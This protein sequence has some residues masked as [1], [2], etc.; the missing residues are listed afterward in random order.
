VNVRIGFGYDIH[1]LT[2]GRKLYIGG[3]EIPAEK[4][5]EGFSDGDALLHAVIDSILGALSLGDIGKHFPPGDERYRNMRSTEMLSKTIK[6]MNDRGA[7]V[8][9]MDCTI[10]LESPKLSP[11]TGSIGESIARITGTDRENISIKAKTKEGLDSTGRGE[12]IEAYAI[13]LLDMGR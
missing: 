7:R 13:T 4:G 3:I 1:R 2:G 12:A 5:E 10:I 9:N 6:L 8:V 11:F